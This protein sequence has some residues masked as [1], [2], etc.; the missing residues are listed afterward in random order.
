V[1]RITV[2]SCRISVRIWPWP[3]PTNVWSHEWCS[4][5]NVASETNNGLDFVW[6]F[7]TR[8]QIPV[9]P[10]WSPQCTTATVCYV[11]VTTVTQSHAVLTRLLE[12]VEDVGSLLF[13]DTAPVNR[14]RCKK[15]LTCCVKRFVQSI[16]KCKLN[17]PAWSP[18]IVL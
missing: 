12:R 16:L 10:V 4:R 9:A 17:T 3:A 8:W 2:R 1:V 15:V 5:N 14:D 18:R 6:K 13:G 7:F 11:D